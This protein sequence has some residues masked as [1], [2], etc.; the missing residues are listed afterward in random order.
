M[1]LCCDRHQFQR[2]VH[3]TGP[4]K[5]RAHTTNFSP[6]RPNKIE[7]LSTSEAT[8]RFLTGSITTE[9]GKSMSMICA[10]P[11]FTRCEKIRNQKK[12]ATHKTEEVIQTL[13]TSKN[14]QKSHNPY[15]N[16]EEKGDK[17]NVPR[18]TSENGT[19]SKHPTH[20]TP[21]RLNSEVSSTVTFPNTTLTKR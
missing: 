10:F 12:R 15:K 3:P 18:K 1:M 6:G 20:K 13:H 17:E 8:V 4:P 11:D 14:Q 21:Q 16:L 5:I 2:T 19:D 7:I 9:Y